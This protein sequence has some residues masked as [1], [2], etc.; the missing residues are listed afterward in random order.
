MT[1]PSYSRLEAGMV[2]IGC[3][4][5]VMFALLLIEV[6]L[7]HAVIILASVRVVI[8]GDLHVLWYTTDELE[9][10]KGSFY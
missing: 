5:M 10:C 1:K 6:R 4:F 8:I 9:L 3:T 2:L 7:T